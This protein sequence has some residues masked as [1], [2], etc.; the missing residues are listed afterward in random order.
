[1]EPPATRAEFSVAIICALPQEADPVVTLFDQYYDNNGDPY[2]KH[3][4]DPNAYT[5]GRIGHHHVVLAH[6]PEM[7]K[8]SAASVATA[9]KSSFEGI[10]IAL[11]VGICGAVPSSAPR[12][13]VILGD[14]I[15]SSSVVEFDFGRQFPDRFERK[16]GIEDTLGR[17]NRRIR[18]LLAKLKSRRDR[19]MFGKKIEKN[20]AYLQE[21]MG[22]TAN[23]PGVARDKLFAPFHRHKHYLQDRARSC[24]C[25]QCVSSEDP[26]CEA[27]ST[28][29]CEVLG[30]DAFETA[31]NLIKRSRL[32]NDR[33][34]PFFHVG[35]I[36]SADTV[37][38]SGQLRDEI[39][40]KN[41]II[42]FE[43]EG[44]GVWDNLPCLID[45]NPQSKQ[46]LSAAQIAC[47]N[48][49]HEIV[50]LLVCCGADPPVVD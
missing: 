13:E 49:Y 25:S 30:C 22:R 42:A 4:E 6:M 15:I 23:Y 14:V 37:M 21:H 19:E 45:L 2:G 41:N 9:L 20:L 8:A 29:N 24:L 3:S 7:G 39:A 50:E 33:P 26:I 40:H 1:M 28:S 34:K 18:A 47:N 46:H 12:A 10:K 48:G 32:D 44:A 17:P 36:G 27:A 43:M 16:R 35:T 5:T 38:K 31:E 11:V